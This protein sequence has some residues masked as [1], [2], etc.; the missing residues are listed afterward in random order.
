MDRER[1][2]ILWIQQNIVYNHITLLDL[3]HMCVCV[4]VCAPDKE[5]ASGRACLFVCVLHR[6]C[7]LSSSNLSFSET[8]CL[9][10]LDCVC[11]RTGELRCGSVCVVVFVAIGQHSEWFKLTRCSIHLQISSSEREER[12]WERKEYCRSIVVITTLLGV[13]LTVASNGAD[14]MSARAHPTCCDTAA[15]ANPAQTCGQLVRWRR[16]WWWYDSN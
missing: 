5:R 12:E 15:A 8:R 11:V 16:R 14:A 13:K 3:L 7:L 6:L 1:E 9:I 10:R 2:L 4:C